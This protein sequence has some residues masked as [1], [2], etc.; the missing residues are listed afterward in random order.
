MK[1]KSFTDK[2]RRIAFSQN[3][4]LRNSLRFITHSEAIPLQ[5]R[6]LAQFQLTTMPK[7]TT[8][9]HV[10]R[11]CV[12]TGRGKSVIREFN[13]SRHAF[14]KLALDDQLPGVTKAV[15]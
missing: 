11:R 3:E 7:S 12:V 14:R 10:M 9:Q 1:G 2:L 5:T 15:W 4:V 13:L 6:Y 8:P